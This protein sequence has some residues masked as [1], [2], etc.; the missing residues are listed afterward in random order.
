MASYEK[1]KKRWLREKK[2]QEERA[3]KYRKQLLDKGIPIFKRYNIKAVYLF[4]SAATGRI[5]QDSDIDLYVSALS[6]DK[7]WKF[8]QELEEAVQLPIDL[9]TDT[10]D[11]TFV[12]KIMERGEK[13]YGV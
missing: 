8:R 11:N 7:Y 1:L 9:Y 2:Q 3:T 12:K 5:W 13:V 4:G 6:A 10:D